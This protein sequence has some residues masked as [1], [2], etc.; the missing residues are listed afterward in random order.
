MKIDRVLLSNLR[1]RFFRFLFLR[2]RARRV[3]SRNLAVRTGGVCRHAFGMAR[4]R[5]THKK[6]R[7][8]NGNPDAVGGS[9]ASASVKL[10]PAD[11]IVTDDWP[12]DVPITAAE[13]DVLE[14][15]LSDML[16]AFLLPRH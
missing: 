4:A 16:D 12:A 8:E 1:L 9:K 11:H 6:I 13:V 15:F 2:R 5:E 10:V 3:A 14:I 7:V